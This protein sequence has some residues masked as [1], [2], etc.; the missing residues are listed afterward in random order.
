[1]NSDFSN[2]DV[3]LMVTNCFDRTLLDNFSP[4]G[5]PSVVSG[6]DRVACSTMLLLDA[7]FPTTLRQWIEVA[8]ARGGNMVP[9][10]RVLDVSEVRLA[11]CA[12]D[13]FAVDFSLL[14]TFRQKAL[15]TLRVLLR[16]LAFRS[17]KSFA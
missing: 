10:T 8:G 13:Q 11:N 16:V 17:W 12:A 3:V 5:V 2:S 9:V 15:L 4:L 1:M 14:W 6:M 7:E